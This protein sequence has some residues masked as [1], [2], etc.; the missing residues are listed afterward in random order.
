MLCFLFVSQLD[1]FLSMRMVCSGMLPVPVL[2]DQRNAAGG[3]DQERGEEHHSHVE[4]TEIDLSTKCIFGE[5][6]QVYERK[7]FDY[8]GNLIMVWM[9]RRWRSSRLPTHILFYISKYFEEE[10]LL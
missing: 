5:S 10:N 9:C 6:L 4:S 8:Y 3:Q 1:F 2:Q 7:I